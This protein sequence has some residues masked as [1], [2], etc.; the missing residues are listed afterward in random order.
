MHLRAL[1][2]PLT[3]VALLAVAGPARAQISMG[4]DP[5]RYDALYGKPVDVSVDDLVQESVSYTNRAVRTKG[6]LELGFSTS[7]RSYLLRGLLYEIQIA[8]VREVATEFEQ[9]ALQMMGRD[10]EITGVF[11]EA[12]Q[13]QAVMTEFSVSPGSIVYSTYLGGLGNDQANDITVRDNASVLVTGSTT[14]ANFPTTPSSIQPA[15]AGDRDAF[16]TNF[17]LAGNAL[18]Y[19]T[20]LGGSGDDESFGIAI[21]GAGNAYVTGRTSSTTNFPTLAPAQ[22][23]YGGGTND[24]FAAKMCPAGSA[25]IYS[26]YLG[27]AG[28]DQGKGIAINGA[29]NAYLTGSTRS[30]N[31]PTLGPFQATLGGVSDAFVTKLSLTGDS[32]LDS[33]YLGGSGADEGQGI[34]VDLVGSAYVAGFTESANFPTMAP[35]QTAF[36]GVRDAFVTKLDANTPSETATPTNTATNTPTATATATN[37][38]TPTNTATN[39][40]T[41]TA[42]ATNTATPTNTATNTP[43][44]T[45]TA[46]DTAT[47]S[48][49]P[50][51]TPL[52]PTNTPTPT[53]TNTPVLSATNTRTRTPTRTPTNTPTRTATP[54]PVCGDVTGDGFVG[55]A[56]LLK[57]VQHAGSHSPLWDVNGDGVVNTTDALIVFSQLGR[58]CHRS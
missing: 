6:R 19:S 26:T 4:D 14:S 50:T 28:D 42:T 34:G 22:L 58:Y 21:D 46:T 18:D 24:A 39:T 43:T 5:S 36:G 1:A 38:A 27:G 30:A 8:P 12:G 35:F 44:G 40:P 3:L 41:A 33:T 10:V 48:S 47:A 37:T 13:T 23:L 49:T 57:V 11:V 25:L 45:A 16:V 31:F 52:P 17:S 32:V 9:A 54:R 29:G 7:Q 53:R 55:I 2:L 51:S 56:D 20:Y 15:L